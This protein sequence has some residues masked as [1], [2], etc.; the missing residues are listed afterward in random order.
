VHIERG[1]RDL[2]TLFVDDADISIAAITVAEL[3]VG[4]EAASGRRRALR[5]AFVEDLIGVLPVEQYDLDVAR[6]H[7]SLLAAARAEGRP[8]GAHDLI[9]AATAMVRNRTVVTHDRGGFEGLPGVDVR[10]A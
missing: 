8:R 9:I 3:L 2:D 5:K 4:V 6:A 7:A 10:S 1:G